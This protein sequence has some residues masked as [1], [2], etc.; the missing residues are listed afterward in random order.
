[1]K[2][3]TVLKYVRSQKNRHVVKIYSYKNTE[4]CVHGILNVTIT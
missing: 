3:F 2:K 1:M 4:R